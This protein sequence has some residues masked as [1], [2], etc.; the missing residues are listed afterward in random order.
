MQAQHKKAYVARQPREWIDVE[1]VVD[2]GSGR[3]LDSR[4]WNISQ[5]GFMADCEVKLPLG[6]ADR[7]R[8]ARTRPGPRRDPLGGGLA[9]RRRDPRRLSRIQFSPLYR[10]RA[11]S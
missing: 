7:R 8:T 5:G 3:L 6:V 10:G 11:S 2:D 1:T 4:I 9:L